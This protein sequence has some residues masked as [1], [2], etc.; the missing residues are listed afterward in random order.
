M[1]HNEINK[2]LLSGDVSIRYQVERDLLGRERKELRQRIEQE[3][4]GAAFLARRREDGHWGQ[5]YYQPKWIS[6]HYTLTDLRNLCV[7]PQ[8]A[9]TKQSVGIVLRDNKG[10]DGGINP[11]VTMPDSDV[12][13]TGMVL[14]FAAYFGI[15]E[16]ELVSL[17]D[18][19]LT[20]WM[21][22]GGFNCQSNYYGAVH[23]SLHTTI[24]V[25][26][27]IR[28]Y[29]RNGYK[30]RTKELLEAEESCREFMLQHRLFKSDKTGE[31]INK[32]FTMLSWPSRWFYD[33]LRALDYF[34]YAKVEYDSRMEDALEVILKKRRN[35][36]TWPL[37]A[38]HPGQTHFEMEK[39]GEPSRWNTL[40]VLRVWKHFQISE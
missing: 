6:T 19:L 8:Q 26:E 37:Q 1:N 10:Q 12:C 34:Q 4:W 35:D 39:S 38:R 29:I 40:R 15:E 23:S 25:A 5:R 14:N 17:V 32:K 27:G 33:I 9:E 16:E 3:G 36:G 21:E 20:E 28:E 31:I 30:Y 2:W 18:F 11:S 24:S 7:S 22:D 13:L